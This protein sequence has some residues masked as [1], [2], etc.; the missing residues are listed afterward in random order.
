MNKCKYCDKKSEWINPYTGAHMCNEHAAEKL[1]QLMAEFKLDDMTFKD[2]FKRDRE[3]SLDD[4][5]N[6]S[7]WSIRKGK[8]ID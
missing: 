4:N 1:S 3:D 5:Y 7:A 8:F 2:F 6:S